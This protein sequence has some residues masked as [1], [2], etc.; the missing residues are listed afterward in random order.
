[1]ASKNRIEQ[2]TCL[3]SDLQAIHKLKENSNVPLEREGLLQYIAEIEIL[4]YIAH[5]LTAQLT[6]SQEKM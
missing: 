4:Q 6:V 3:I 2:A 1:M 5:I